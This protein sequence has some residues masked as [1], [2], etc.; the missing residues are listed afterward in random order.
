[1]ICGEEVDGW[2]YLDGDRVI[3]VEGG[4]LDDAQVGRQLTSAPAIGQ[5]NVAIMAPPPHF[6]VRRNGRAAPVLFE[7]A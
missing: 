5:A 7:R 4:L 3:D 6:T 1:V 2:S